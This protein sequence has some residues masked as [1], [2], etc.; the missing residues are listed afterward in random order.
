MPSLL[1]EQGGM[2]AGR[3]AGAFPPEGWMLWVASR[4]PSTEP[5]GC[6]SRPPLIPAEVLPRGLFFFF[7]VN[8]IDENFKKSKNNL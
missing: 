6:D 8:N 7:R 1:L 3:G 4:P 5:G 2:Q